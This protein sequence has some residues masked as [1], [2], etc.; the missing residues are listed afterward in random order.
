MSEWVNLD[1]LDGVGPVA[2]KRR[3][4]RE[5]DALLDHE[6][7][8][9]AAVDLPGVVRLVERRGD[10]APALVTRFIGTHSLATAPTPDVDDTIAIVASL[11]DTVA[12]LHRLGVRHGAIDPS[13][14]LLGPGRRPVLCGFSRAT[15][16]GTPA[17]AVPT[18]AEDVAAI[19]RVMAGLLAGHDGIEPIP[20]HRTSRG[21]TWGGYR[22]RALL[23]L[24]DHCQADQPGARPSAASLAATIGDLL[25]A[26]RTETREPR[27]HPA[28]WLRSALDLVRARTSTWPRPRPRAGT[29]RRVLALTLATLA[30]TAAAI[31]ARSL[32]P[33][34]TDA[35]PSESAVPERPVTTST[36]STTSTTMTTTTT[37]A[38]CPSAAPDDG[39]DLDGDG[40]PDGAV[41]VSDHTA[42]V[43]GE[44]FVLGRPGD[45]VLVGDW[46]CDGLVTAV[47]ARA[48]PPALWHFPTWARADETVTARLVSDHVDPATVARRPDDRG[49]DRLVATDTRTG[50]PIPVAVTP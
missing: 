13:H 29:R 42:T 40:C 5:D 24:A 30:V 10:P 23:T 19:G 20:N 50:A 7:A 26:D 36:T 25:D 6:A 15:L 27:V 49:C 18:A 1:I 17:T 35:A 45:R 34:P 16:P 3:R 38:P 28:A 8:V 9:L 12:D 39:A 11:V 32:R 37:R 31:A 44:R 4:P 41:V 33:A 46:S 48:D 47:L 43:A 14:V 2:L 21:R 22:P